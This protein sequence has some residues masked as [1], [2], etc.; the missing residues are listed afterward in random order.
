MLQNV[1]RFTSNSQIWLLTELYGVIS[2]YIMDLHLSWDGVSDVGRANEQDLRQVERHIL[3]KLQDGS[4]RSGAVIF[5][6]TG[7]SVVNSEASGC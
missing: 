5:S 3:G 1:P 2:C 7:E 6:W 4:T